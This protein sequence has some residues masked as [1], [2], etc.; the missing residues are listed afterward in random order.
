MDEAEALALARKFVQGVKPKM[1]PVTVE[2]Y[3]AAINGVLKYEDLGPNESGYTIEGK[4]KI[5]I[6][7]NINDNPERQ[8][9]TICHEIAHIILELPSEHK[10][11]PS[12][13]FV[14]RHQ[15]EMLCDAFAAE[16]LLP[17]TLF[18]PAMKGV[19]PSFAVLE[20]FSSRFGSS[21]SATGSRFASLADFPCAFV[22]SDRGIVRYGARSTTLRT[23]NAW[24]APK[25]PLPDGS[26]AKAA[27]EGDADLAAGEIPQD[28]W[29]EN[30]MGR[31]YMWEESRHFPKRDQTLSLLWIDEEE[32]PVQV[33]QSG[34]RERE[35]LGLEE[36]T[37]IL[38]WPKR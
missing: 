35:D 33:H 6:C 13:S 22:F 3:V 34:Q 31:D 7:I 15:N 38:P 18:K 14:K 9:F 2:D 5:F 30:W 24:I 29:F 26:R 8:K 21:L 16:L 4:G 20:D 25:R 27:R 23:A 36:L 11:I 37:G 10:E 1:L 12:W 28:V 19:E 17:Y 32:L